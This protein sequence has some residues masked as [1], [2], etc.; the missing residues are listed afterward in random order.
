MRKSLDVQ[1]LTEDIVNLAM[2]SYLDSIKDFTFFDDKILVSKYFQFTTKVRQ[3]FS[4]MFE[5]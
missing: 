5:N 4:K 1:F 2:M 3:F